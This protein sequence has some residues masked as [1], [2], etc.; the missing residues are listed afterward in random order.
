MVEQP[1]TANANNIWTIWPNTSLRLPAANANGRIV[2]TD[3]WVGNVH[4][5][6]VFQITETSYTEILPDG[7]RI[8]NAISTAN[9]VI[10]ENTICMTNGVITL[11][12]DSSIQIGDTGDG[13]MVNSSTCSIGNSTANMSVNASSFRTGNSSSNITANMTG[14]TVY[15]PAAN[16]VANLTTFAIAN[17]SANMVANMSTIRIS[18]STANIV[19]NLSG[20]TISNSTGNAVLNP[21][22]SYVGNSLFSVSLQAN[23]VANTI[24]LGN[25]SN[26]LTINTTTFTLSG[27]NNHTI[28]SGTI[29]LF[30]QTA[31][32]TGFTKITTY[33]DYA[34]RIVN[35]T[36]GTGGSV[37]FTTAFASKSVTGSISGSVGGTTLTTSQIPSHTHS[38]SR[39]DSTSGVPSGTYGYY[40]FYD[41]S[42]SYTTGANGGG[43][44]HN[45]DGSTLSFSGTAINMAVNY[46]DCIL[47]QAT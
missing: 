22:G 47:A 32:P 23:N 4:I 38:Y 8:A 9:V 28:P 17:S 34:I 43:T 30:Q 39:A 19:A 21:Y 25:T 36:A 26:Y 37:A 7:I 20:M 33:N 3:Y 10:T 5:G 15:T 12:N 1:N 29:M 31:A 35:A 27:V 13:S 44:S 40:Y 6:N 45:H 14:M 24:F 41:T 18:N 2:N 46:V 16:M 42:G 11:G